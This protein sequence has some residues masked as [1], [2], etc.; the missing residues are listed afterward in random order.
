[1]FNLNLKRMKK[2]LFLLMLAVS[3]TYSGFGQELIKN[4]DF[5]LPD[6]GRKYFRIDSIEYWTTDEPT[7]DWNGRE[8]ETWTS[9]AVAYTDDWSMP[10]YQVVGTISSGATDFAISFDANF[11][12]TDWSDYAPT[13]CV[14]FSSFTGNDRTS[15]ESID[16]VKFEIPFGGYGNNYINYTGTFSIPAASK[17]AG[18]SLAIELDVLPYVNDEGLDPNC[19]FQFD[20]VSVIQTITSVVKNP[21]AT[22]LKIY[23]V[24]A[25]DM[26]HISNDVAMDYVTLTDLTGKI[27]RKETGI[28]KEVTLSI[29]D[30]SSGIYFVNVRL[31]DKT[32]VQKV[33]VQ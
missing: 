7:S 26:I 33:I 15:R 16:S 14:I 32:V 11:L 3:M 20:N 8:F 18:D 1:M 24:P 4:G 25:T 9:G 2:H 28:N 31:R 30:V 12:W 22:N 29:R 23:P 6:D 27:I 17:Y 13:V 10:I 21:E 5:S 19:W